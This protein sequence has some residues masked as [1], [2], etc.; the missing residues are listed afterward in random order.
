MNIFECLRESHELQRSLCSRLVRS[1]PEQG[2]RQDIFIALRTELAAHAA[3]EERYLYVPI[4]MDDAGLVV[5]R[6]ALS[7]HHEIDELCEAL[8]VRDKTSTAW[9]EK[10]KKL[11]HEVRHH[12]KEEEQGFFQQAGKILSETQKK[13]LATK[14]QRELARMRKSLASAG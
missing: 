2:L 9:L 1:K 6:H 5:S 12:L 3:A 10:A 8:S 13:T 4:L 11:S 14:Y 7:E